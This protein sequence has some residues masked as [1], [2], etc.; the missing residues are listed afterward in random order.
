MIIDNTLYELKP[1]K[2]ADGVIITHGLRVFNN[3]LRTGTIDLLY[4]D[5]WSERNE[6]NGHIEWWFYMSIDGMREHVRHLTSAS[7]VATIRRT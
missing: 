3:D 6:N 2:T 1:V 7:R 4:R 5:P